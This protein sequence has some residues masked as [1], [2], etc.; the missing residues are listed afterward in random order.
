VCLGFQL[1]TYL[2]SMEER[3]GDETPTSPLPDPAGFHAHLEAHDLLIGEAEVCA[4]PAAMIMEAYAAMIGRKAIAP[5][6]LPQECSSLGIA[7]EDFDVFVHHAANLWNDLVLYVIQASQ[8]RPTLADSRLPPDVQQRLD[9]C[10][11]ERGAQLQAGQTGLVVD[12]ARGVQDYLGRPTAAWLHAPPAS[13]M[14][15]FSPRPGS[16][17]ATVLAWL[18]EVAETEME[19]IAPDVASALLTQ[20]A[21]YD[22]YEATVLA[23]LN[24]H[25][26]CLLNALGQGPP[27]APLTAAALSHVCGR[28][29]RDWAAVGT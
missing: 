6:G 16:L 26:S 15:P 14:A 13:F 4:G 17:A 2:A 25:L 9:A 24:Q 28:T 3:Y 5:E 19:T 7:W 27:G 8:F 11:Q 18:R 10:L 22:V 1:A 12:I 20:L 21:P 23:A 29:W